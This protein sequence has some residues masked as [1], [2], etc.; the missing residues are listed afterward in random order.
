[1][2]KVV[3]GDV[4]ISSHKKLGEAAWAWSDAPESQT[5]W[6][7]EAISGGWRNIELISVDMLRQCLQ[8][9]KHPRIQGRRI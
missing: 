7:C 8:A 5:V 3:Q 6:R 1:M 4:E 9:M 2:Y